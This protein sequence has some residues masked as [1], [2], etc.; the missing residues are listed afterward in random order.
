MVCR[1]GGGRG[2]RARGRGDA[3]LLRRVDL[4]ASIGGSVHGR[5]R[6]VGVVRWGRHA[7]HPVVALLLLV[8]LGAVVVVRRLRPGVAAVDAGE[9]GSAKQP[10]VVA[11]R[12]ETLLES[13]LAVH[14]ADDEERGEE[15][16]EA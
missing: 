10:A 3:V 2:R 15:R 5:P 6:G 14:V 11:E 9:L 16:C 7:L 13:P 1:H 12:E 8:V 4:G